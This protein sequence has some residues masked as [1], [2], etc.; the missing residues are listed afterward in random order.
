[1]A[2]AK[3]KKSAAKAEKMSFFGQKPQH[4]SETTRGAAA[5]DG[6]ED[7]DTT[8][9]HTDP[10]T[11]Q[12]AEYLTKGF[13][14]KAIEGM[15]TKL[16]TTWQM[17][18]TTSV[19]Q[20][21][22]ELSS[23]QEDLSQQLKALQCQMEHVE[24]RV[25]D[26]ENRARRNNLRLRGV[27]E[28]VLM[29]DLPIYV[30]GLLRA[31]APDIPT[32]MLLMDRVHRVPKPKQ[33]PDSVPRD[34]LLRVHFYHIKE[35]ILRTHRS[36]ADPHED[37]STIRIMAD[38]SAATLRCRREF[39]HTTTELRTHGIRYRWGFPTKIILTRNGKTVQISTPEEGKKLLASWGLDHNPTTGTRS[40]S[41]RPSRNMNTD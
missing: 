35:H 8:L 36:R 27:P 2:N 25:A 28:T 20:H 11:L 14:E 18:A 1:M 17:T 3:T 21:C 24:A 13:F 41:P 16:I 33:L 19:E 31:Y 15:A 39:L 26:Q 37:Y 22:T 30:Q 6:A 7:S 32:D 9:P 4:M 40:N 23:A 10:E 5:Q 29:D 34:V 12:P 38:I